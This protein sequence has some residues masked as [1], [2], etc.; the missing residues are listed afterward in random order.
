MPGTDD[1]SWSFSSYSA[2]TLIFIPPSD[3]PLPGASAVPQHLRG[4]RAGPEPL[5]VEPAARAVRRRARRPPG[6]CSTVPSLISLCVSVL[7]FAATVDHSEKCTISSQIAF[8]SSILRCSK[9]KM[10]F[11]WGITVIL[12]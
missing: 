1:L 2:Y 10:G 9:T 6:K 7:Q 4:L 8:Q 5:G 3:N 11:K 12:I